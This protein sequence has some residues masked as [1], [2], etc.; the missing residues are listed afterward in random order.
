M[1]KILQALLVIITLFLG[2][3]NI[4]DHRSSRLSITVIC[5]IQ[6]RVSGTEPRNVKS[7][8][9]ILLQIYTNCINSTFIS[10]LYGTV[11]KNTEF[12]K[13]F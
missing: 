13:M 12:Q 11:L 2:R 7:S 8:K 10:F 5:V 1:F 4:F 3:T 9:V 6:N